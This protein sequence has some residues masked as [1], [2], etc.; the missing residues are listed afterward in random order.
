MVTHRDIIMPEIVYALDKMGDIEGKSILE[1]GQ[2]RDTEFRTLIESYGLEYEA[3][4]NIIGI[5]NTDKEGNK[6][7]TTL[8]NN[9]HTLTNEINNLTTPAMICCHATNT[10]HLARIMQKR[11]S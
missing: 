11:D 3:T 8:N 6:Q 7:S 1:I 9:K 10:P 5:N 4:D 2:G